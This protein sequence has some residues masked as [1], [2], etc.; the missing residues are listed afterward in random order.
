MNSNAF[1]ALG[2]KLAIITVIGFGALFVAKNNVKSKKASKFQPNVK[3]SA[4]EQNT[5]DYYSNL[6][7]IKPGFPLPKDDS[8]DAGGSKYQRKSKY[9]GSGNSYLSRKGG[10]RLGFLDRRE[11]D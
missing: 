9:E 6:A 4:T 3:V 10:D 1:E 11:N 5:G 7:K 8:S 2:K